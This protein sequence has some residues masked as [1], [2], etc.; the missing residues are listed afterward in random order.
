[1]TEALPTTNTAD[2]IRAELLAM[3]KRVSAPSSN[4]ISTKGKLF[5]LPDGKSST[6]PLNV[7]ILDFVAV[8][9]FYEG[10][11]N[12]QNKSPPTCSAVSKDLDTMVPSASAPKPQGL[13]C[14]DCSKNAWGSGNGGRG[15]ACKNTRR[16][17]VV[18]PDFTK[19]TVPMTLYVSPTGLKG[20]DAYIRRLV[21]EYT[22]RPIDVTTTISF[23]PNHMYPSLQFSF[24][25]LN[26][27]VAVAEY[28]RTLHAEMLNREPDAP[29]AQ[30]A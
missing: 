28:L 30:A 24:G 20:W 23:D 26:P 11:Y 1:M 14:N 18:P 10:V 6:G 15:K 3:A 2:R 7:V 21:I 13:N 29:V 25:E 9:S 8:N 17:I 19:D 12:P 4:K 16:L 27:N 22:A 5:T